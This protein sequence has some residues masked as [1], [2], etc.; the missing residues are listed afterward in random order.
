MRKSSFLVE[1]IFFYAEHPVV[2][3][4]S[5]DSDYTSKGIWRKKS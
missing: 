5:F 3:S 2:S 1:A 4:D